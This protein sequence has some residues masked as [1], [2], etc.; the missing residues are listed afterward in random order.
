MNRTTKISQF[1]IHIPIQQQILQL[2]IPVNDMSLVKIVDCRQ[3]L[4]DKLGYLSLSK[5]LL[6]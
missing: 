4:V 1:N 5:M 2:D 3:Q 6:L